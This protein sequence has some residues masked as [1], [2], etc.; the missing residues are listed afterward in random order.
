MSTIELNRR[1][2][3]KLLRD[4]LGHAQL[5]QSMVA[6][7]RETGLVPDEYPAELLF[8]RDLVLEGE[9]SE[10]V[11]LVQL[12]SHSE[13]YSDVMYAI[14]RQRF[15]ELLH[16]QGQPSP[17]PAAPYPAPR[18]G[19]IQ[20]HLQRL[21]RLC[22]DRTEFA[23]LSCLITLPNLTDHPVF[24]DWEVKASRHQLFQCVGRK[25][26]EAIYHSA[27]D[28]I[29]PLS[30]AGDLASDRLVQLLAKGLLYEQCEATV[31]D[32]F[33]GTQGQPQGIVD[34]QKC[35]S[36]VLTK[37]REHELISQTVSVEVVDRMQP[38]AGNEVLADQRLSG[39][40]SSVS[41]GRSFEYVPP[42]NGKWPLG[43]VYTLRGGQSMVPQVMLTPE[44]S[45]AHS[46]VAIQQG[47]KTAAYFGQAH[48]SLVQPAAQEKMS[49]Q[50]EVMGMDQEYTRD[51]SHSPTTCPAR[52]VPSTATAGRDSPAVAGKDFAPLRTTLFSPLAEEEQTH[53]DRS[54][55]VGSTRPPEEG[56]EQ[57]PVLQEGVEQSP[58][59]QEG[60]EQSPV[61]QEGV[62]QSPVLQKQLLDSQ[63]VLLKG[64][65]MPSAPAPHHTPTQSLSET[66]RTASQKSAHP[67]VIDST[68]T[69]PPQ[70]HSPLV[71][72]ASL[73][74]QSSE[75]DE[76]GLHAGLRPSS[77]L[78]HPPPQ[79]IHPVTVE[80]VDP[81]ARG[82]GVRIAEGALPLPRMATPELA[83]H[84]ETAIDSSTPKP[85]HSRLVGGA[86]GVPPT[87]PV[88]YVSGTHGLSDT[89]HR[90]GVRLRKTLSAAMEGAGGG[91]SSQGLAPQEVEL[92]SDAPY[93]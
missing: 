58:V 81:A 80:G 74:A 26:A 36:A 37:S 13:S 33:T 84:T 77:A 59:L 62:E 40:K 27:V 28:R 48:T 73:H 56:V 17:P 85:T 19:E 66:E 16:T 8:F 89:P 5:M 86:G 14:E 43:G 61:L 64:M 25:M 34:L 35:I 60:V 65:S 42:A 24:S 38:T 88:P 68:P 2:L 15:L 49:V 20:E 23:T 78:H 91:E 57:S 76:G 11:N 90:R 1:G 87:S 69:A 79:A 71:A 12:L 92:V 63:P 39:A 45:H 72:M 54:S 4:L 51:T 7:E 52:V 18:K 44:P 50:T 3:I 55:L 32:H 41:F 9:W 10:V 46:A 70:S 75:K 31:T 83:L 6:L 93:R 21:E 22:P 82:S 67:Q 47:P 29:F 30:S 53:S